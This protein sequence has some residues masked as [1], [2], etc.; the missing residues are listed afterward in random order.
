MDEVELGK[1]PLKLTETPSVILITFLGSDC[2]NRVMG[3]A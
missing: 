2:E 1:K 3:W